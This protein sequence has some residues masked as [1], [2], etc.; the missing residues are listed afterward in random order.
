MTDILYRS[1]LHNPEQARAALTKGMLPWLGQQ[2]EQGH[3]L[4]LEARLLDDDITDKQRAYL[5]GVVLAEIAQQAVVD[6]RRWPMAVWKEH[7]RREFLG[8]RV[9]TVI[10]PMTG[11]KSRRRER[12]STEDLGV[13]R[14]AEYIDRIIAFAATDLGVAVSEP[15][16]PELRP[17]RRKKRESVDP[18]TGEVLETA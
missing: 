12:I 1:Q 6:G 16:P 10:N 2:L 11:R 9:V 3:A 17:G 4:V 15:L 7:F 8:H 18:E 13:R 14:M 5:H